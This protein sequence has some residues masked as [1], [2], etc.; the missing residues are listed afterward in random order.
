MS[1]RH[2]ETTGARDNR[3]VFLEGL[4]IDSSRIV[5]C[6]QVHGDLIRCVT[7][8]DCGSGALSDDTA[9]PGTD[10]LLT[11]RADV[12]LAIFTADCL[13]IALYD[14]RVQAAGLVHAGWRGT[15]AA[16]AAKAV[17]LMRSRF[18][19]RASD[20][21]VEFGPAIRKCCYEVGAEFTDFFDYGLSP[22]GSRWHLD[23]AAVNKKQLLEAGVDPQKIADGGVCTSCNHREFFSFRKEGESCGRTMSVVM[24]KGGRT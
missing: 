11:D 10:G 5:C 20:L 1:L 6:Q 14:L 3:R 12:P 16:I 17:A 7:E 8:A 13:S 22:A 2:G 15:K 23:L 19:S 9:L 4:G 18:S 24:L 21:C